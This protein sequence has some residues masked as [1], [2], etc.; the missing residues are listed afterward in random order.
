LFGCGNIHFR[1]VSTSGAGTATPPE[2]T[3]SFKGVR[4]EEFENTKG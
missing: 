1:S 2:F 4:L 3:P